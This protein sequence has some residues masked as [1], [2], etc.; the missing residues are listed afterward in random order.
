VNIE[1]GKGQAPRAVMRVGGRTLSNKVQGEGPMRKQATDL[2][3]MGV[4]FEHDCR[5]LNKKKL[6]KR[7]GG[8]KKTDG[9]TVVGS[10]LP[11]IIPKGKPKPESPRG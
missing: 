9:R 6:T 11:P 5:N 7:S 3:F 1:A 2:R 4:W 8:Q 10:A